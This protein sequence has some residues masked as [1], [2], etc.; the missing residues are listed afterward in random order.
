MKIVK[1]T[2]IQHSSP[3]KY[4]DVINAFP[5][6]NFFVKTN[7]TFICSHNCAFFDEISFIR[8]KDVQQQK[9]KAIDM[10]NTAIGGMK[11]RFLYKGKNPTMLI[12]ASSKR[13]DKSFLEEHMKKKLKSEGSNVYI[14]DGPV[15]E[16]QPEEKFSKERFKIA[17]GN[18]FLESVIIPDGADENEYRKKGYSKFIDVP[19]DYK[20][21]FIDDMDRSLCDFAGISSSSIT[22]YISGQAWSETITDRIKNPFP[23]DILRIGNGPEDKDVQY[24][25]FFHM[26]NIDP[27]LKSKPFFIHLDMSK[28]GDKTG[29][30]GVFIKGK[31]TSTDSSMQDRDLFYSVAFAISIEAPKGREISFEKNRQF[32]RWLKTKGFNIKGITSD[33]YQSADLQQILKAEGYPIEILSVDRCD[34]DKICKPYQAFKNA[35]YEKRI[36][37]FDDPLL[38]QEVTELERDIDTG[39]VDHPDGGSKDKSDAVC[40]AMYNASKHAEEFAYD[41]GESAEEMLRVNEDVTLNDKEQLTLDLENELK[42]MSGIFHKRGEDATHP[43]NFGISSATE[44]YY[45]YD[46]II[47]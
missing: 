27:K 20:A 22:K 37:V 19:V 6:H 10:I 32:I 35:I 5:H 45:L 40:G 14:S 42:K 41:Y 25:N 30:A 15:W 34:T 23:T 9:E 29:I 8:N 36:E 3:K 12:L 38:N 31:K 24:Y 43:S 33:T 28:T 13:S 39:K 46:D 17:V 47:M 44:D 16:A 21:N 7:K 2:K 18:K 11:T 26:E 1:I 4:Y